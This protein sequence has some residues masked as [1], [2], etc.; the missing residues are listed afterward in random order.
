MKVF[1]FVLV[2]TI[3][4]ASSDAVIRLSLHSHFMEGPSGDSTSIKAAVAL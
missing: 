2:A 1:A 3:L 4:E